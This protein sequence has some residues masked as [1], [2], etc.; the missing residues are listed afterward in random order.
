MVSQAWQLQVNTI[1]SRDLLAEEETSSGSG[2]CKVNAAGNGFRG[3]M[4]LTAYEG[5]PSVKPKTW[6]QSVKKGSAG[7]KL[8][9]EAATAV[10]TDWKVARA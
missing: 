9:V 1:E 7:E 6:K 2:T 3:C 5:S 8:S 4:M 10:Q